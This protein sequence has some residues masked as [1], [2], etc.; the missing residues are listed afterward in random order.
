METRHIGPIRLEEAYAI[1]DQIEEGYW[2]RAY[3]TRP[4]FDENLS[5]EK[6]YEPVYRFGWE[7]RRWFYDRH[8]NDVEELLKQA[9]LRQFQG[10][11]NFEWSLVRR[12]VLDAWE[13]VDCK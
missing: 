9:W 2:K 6:D 3:L 11:T 5:F 12:M 7:T 13:N 8:F 1:D 4:Y 10:Q